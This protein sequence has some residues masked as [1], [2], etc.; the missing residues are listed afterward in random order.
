MKQ[1][2]NTELARHLFNSW[3]ANIPSILRD[4]LYIRT[5]SYGINVNDLYK[6]ISNWEDISDAEVHLVKEIFR[7][8]NEQ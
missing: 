3:Y 8:I 6:M 2:K 4:K 5:K 7:D 1:N